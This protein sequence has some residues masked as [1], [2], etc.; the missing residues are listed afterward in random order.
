VLTRPQHWRWPLKAALASV[1]T[2]ARRLP[3]FAARARREPLI[4]GYHRVVEDFGAA[5]QTEMPSMLTS[6]RTFEQHLDCLAREFTFVSLDE[7]GARLF[8]GEPFARPVAAI[9]F[10]D[11]YRDVFEQAFPVLRRRGIPATAFVV[12]D[13]IGQTAWQVHDRLYYLLGKGFARWRD[14]RRVLRGLLGELGLAE[15]DLLPT[16]ASAGSPAATVSTLLP[17][18]PIADVGRLAGALE[19]VVAN[20]QVEIPQSLTWPML[21]EMQRAGVT[22]GSHTRRHIS[23][24]VESAA[25]VDA[26][27]RESKRVLEARLGAPVLHFAYPGGQFTPETVDAAARAGYRFAYTACAHRDPRHPAL[28]QERLLLWE[29]SS[30]DDR[31]TF[32]PALFQCQAHRLWPPARRCHRRH[33][34]P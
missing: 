13:L 24:P 8:S 1:V 34:E 21:I 20:G 27:L 18:L 29:H 32:H 15:Q 19:A 6:R 9:T 11:G 4:L 23:M 31:G 10:D 30:L 2:G 12:T 26:E 7:I 28:T 14:P 3:P 22:I 5:S 17:A 16:P 25:T 33:I